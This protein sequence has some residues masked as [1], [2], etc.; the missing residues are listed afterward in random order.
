MGGTPNSEKERD[1]YND[2]VTATRAGQGETYIDENGDMQRFTNS[3]NPLADLANLTE[4]R[5]KKAK[6]L[7]TGHVVRNTVQADMSSDF[8]GL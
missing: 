3:G 2:A 6:A 7:Q 5:N 4:F 8:T 1:R